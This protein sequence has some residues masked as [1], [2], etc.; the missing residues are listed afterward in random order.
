VGIA[1]NCGGNEGD[2]QEGLPYR[3]IAGKRYDAFGQ[4]S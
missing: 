2:E 1:D 3:P 4:R